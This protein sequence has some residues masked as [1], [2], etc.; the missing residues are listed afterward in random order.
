MKILAKA[1]LFT[2]IGATSFSYANNEAHEVKPAFG[3]GGAIANLNADELAFWVASV[4][5]FKKVK[6]VA[7]TEPGTSGAGLGPRFNSNSCVSCHS[8]PATGGTSPANNPLIAVATEFGATNQIPFFITPTGPVREARFINI[9]G[10]NTPD[11]S[12]H[13]LF[14]ITGRQDASGCHIVQPDF[15]A[16]AAKKNLSF[17]IPTPLFGTGLIEAIPESAII[18]NQNANLV[19]KRSLGIHGIPNRTASTNTPKSDGSTN[20]SGNDATI[21]RFGW[22]AQNKS[23]SIFAGEA[24]NVELGVTNE[25]FPNERDETVGCVFNGIPE[26][27]TNFSAKTPIATISDSLSNEI[28]MRFLAQ[29]PEPISTPQT[30]RGSN[31]FSSVGCDLCHTPSFKTGSASSASLAN[32]TVKLFSDLLLHHMGEGLEDNITQGFAGPD[33]FRTAPL[34]GISK[35]LF[36]LHDGR[37][38][39]INTAIQA[40][41]S[42]QSEANAVIANFNKLTTAQQADLIAFVQSL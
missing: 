4:A 33:Q 31:L 9:D 38:T 39:D 32:Q 21:S 2:L 5:T 27:H 26:D 19:A 16:E 23:L 6:S 29:P 1:L 13:N 24:M 3:F 30:D 34:W 10:G 12:V 20:R 22:K 14:V 11:G 40:H 37:A 35:R 36:F 42:P 17:R 41:S 18:A 25:H 8:F 15:N 7:G 28:F